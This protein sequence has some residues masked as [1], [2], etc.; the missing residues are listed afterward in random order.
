MTNPRHLGRKVYLEEFN[1]GQVVVVFEVL[2]V[3]VGGLDNLG[4]KLALEHGRYGLVDLVE[5]RHRLRNVTRDLA[6]NQS[7]KMC[8]K[9]LGRLI[10]ASTVRGADIFPKDKNPTQTSGFKTRPW[11]VSI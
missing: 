3:V 6:Q 4:A 8:G 7:L 11:G 1:F 5:D 2:G 9:K 10:M